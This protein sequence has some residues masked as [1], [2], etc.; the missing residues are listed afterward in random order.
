ME[1]TLPA[2]TPHV[3]MSRYEA[4]SYLGVSTRKL[5]LIIREGAFRTVQIGRSRK[6][7]RAVL[8]AFIEQNVRG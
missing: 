7:E 2:K 6:I 8:D 5:D 4:A 3:L 1:A